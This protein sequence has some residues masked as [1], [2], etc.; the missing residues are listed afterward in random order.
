M[1]E[2]EK[3]RRDQCSR[4][5]DG[6]PEEDE[7][8]VSAAGELHVRLRGSHARSLS[9]AAGVTR[10]LVTGMSG[11]GKSSAVQALGDRGHRAVDTDTDTWSRW[12]TL[13]DGSPDWVWREG[14]IDRLLAGHSEGALYVAGCKTNQGRFYDRFDHVV[15][16]SA[17]LGVLLARIDVRSNNPYGKTPEERAL[18]AHHLETVEP[19]LRATAT[20]EIDASVPLDEVVRRLEELA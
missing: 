6:G 10:I 5:A 19:R 14:A 13:E 3:A 4:N 17:P 1:H 7:A 16:L 12:V 2:G 8:E 9:Y 18:I 20:L 15:L 11:T